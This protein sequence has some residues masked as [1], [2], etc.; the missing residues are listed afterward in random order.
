MDNWDWLFYPETNDKERILQRH[1]LMPEWSRSTFRILLSGKSDT[2][3]TSAIASCLLKH[4]NYD[5]LHVFTPNGWDPAYEAIAA[6]LA[7]LEKETGCKIFHLYDDLNDLPE[8]DEYEEMDENGDI[9]YRIAVFDDCCNLKDQDKIKSYFQAGRKKNI[10]CFY[11]THSYYK[12]PKFIRDQCT[13]FGFFSNSNK[14]ERDRI[15]AELCGDM[16]N[17]EYMKL[18]NKCCCKKGD[19][20]FIDNQT[21]DPDLKY[22]R[23]MI[24]PL[25]KK[26]KVNEKFE[27]KKPRKRKTRKK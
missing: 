15:R 19:F 17:Q 9:I 13:H 26:S 25:V 8:L 12:T 14:F 27:V 1:K 5:E 16:T 10:G 23:S 7:P 6:Q 3:K 22:R 2:G 4:M 20:L 18:Y 11:L 24:Y 21:E